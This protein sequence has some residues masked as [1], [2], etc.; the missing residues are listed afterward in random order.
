MSFEPRDYLRHILAETEFLLRERPG[1]T[2]DSFLEDETLQWAFVRSLE[3]IGE[4]A[5]QVPA[6]FRAQHPEI[7]CEPRPG[8]GTA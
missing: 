4:A 5:K 6:A 1:L 7:E 3:I 2:L 8:C